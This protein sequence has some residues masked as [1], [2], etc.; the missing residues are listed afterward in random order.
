MRIALK[1]TCSAQGQVSPNFIGADLYVI[2]EPF[3]YTGGTLPCT[4]LIISSGIQRIFVASIDPN[5]SFNG[6]GIG[7]LKAAGIEVITGI[8]HEEA[9]RLN[10]AFFHF[11]NY[12]KPY[13]TLKAVTLDGRHSTQNGDSKWINSVVSRADVH[14][15]S[16]THDA[17]LV[18]V[19]TVLHDNP[20][21]TTCLPH[22]GKN[23]IRIILDRHLMTPKNAHIVKDGVALSMDNA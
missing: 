2:L 1:L 11:V 22:G 20:F 5:P 15:L 4:N 10:Q 19:Q 8:L 17:I 9:E 12:G 13:V 6:T 18:D 7:L 16:H 14:H 3:S 21:L 23:P